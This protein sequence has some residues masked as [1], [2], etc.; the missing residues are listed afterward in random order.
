[1]RRSPACKVFPAGS[2]SSATH[3]GAPV[4]VDYAHKPDALA[5]VLKTLRPITTAGSSSSSA[6]AATATAASGR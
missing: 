3:N 1:V 5:A 6:A 2:T 4:V